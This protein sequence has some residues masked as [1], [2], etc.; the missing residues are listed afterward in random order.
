MPVTRPSLVGLT[1]LWRR[2]NERRYPALKIGRV[3][4]DEKSDKDKQQGNESKR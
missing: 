3:E 1:A 2:R 4:K